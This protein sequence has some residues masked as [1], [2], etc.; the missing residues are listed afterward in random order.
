MIFKAKIA[1][2]DEDDLFSDRGMCSDFYVSKR[3]PTA[4][5]VVAAAERA[6]GEISAQAGNPDIEEWEHHLEQEVEHNPR[7]DETER[8]ALVIA[9]RG[10]GLFKENVRVIEHACR[11]TSVDNPAHLRA[12]HLKPW[13]DATNEERLNGENGLLLTPSIDHL[14]DKGFISLEDFR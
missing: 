9:R 10:Q 13:R 6:N 8:S 5:Q 1:C 7:I 14:L 11:M 12:S 3:V 2:G 4:N